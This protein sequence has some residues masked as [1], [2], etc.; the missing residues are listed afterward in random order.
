M[1]IPENIA[2]QFLSSYGL[3]T[4]QGN[5]AHSIE[6]A[7]ELAKP[8]DYDCV[9]KALI[10]M[11]GRGKA[12]GVKICH[13]LTQ[14]QQSC[15]TLL[16]SELLGHRVSTVLVEERMPIEREIYAGVVANTATDMI[17]IILSFQ[18]GMEIEN[19]AQKDEA[20]ILQFSVEPG[21]VLPIYRI[22]QW[23]RQAKN[24]NLDTD[25]LAKVLVQLYRAAIDIDAILL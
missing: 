4:P 20:A 22:R 12:G 18:G 23:L 13:S 17:D 16:G 19:T 3:Q 10:P 15:E 14:V 5:V 25:A 24:L 21:D 8:L 9:I 7:L 1:I 11:G 6:E 2:K